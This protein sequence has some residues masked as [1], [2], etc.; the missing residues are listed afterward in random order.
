M[1]RTA[2]EM[3]PHTSNFHSNAAGGHKINVYGFSGGHATCTVELKL[4][5]NQVSNLEP[6]GP[7]AVALPPRHRGSTSSYKK[8]EQTNKNSVLFHIIIFQMK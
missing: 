7:V 3:A 4:K 5:K 8:P 2:S 6:S 1:P